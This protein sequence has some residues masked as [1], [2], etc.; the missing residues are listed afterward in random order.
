MKKSLLL[1]S[2]ALLAAAATFSS[3]NSQENEMS[4]FITSAG[5]GDGANLGGLAGADAHCANLASTA[6]SRG[7]TWRAY[8]SAHE[9]SNSPAVNCSAF[10]K[11]PRN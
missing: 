7:K 3:I 8:L 2:A 10:N 1:T 6:G 11:P 5:S 9:T 4:F